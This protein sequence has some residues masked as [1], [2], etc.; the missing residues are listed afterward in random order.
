MEG[1][2]SDVDID[3]EESD[4]ETGLS[5]PISSILNEKVATE[6][7]IGISGDVVLRLTQ[8][9]PAEGNY[10]VFMDN[11]FTSY[12]LVV[13]LKKRGLLSVGTVRPNRVPGCTLKKD[14]E[15]KKAGRGSYDFRTEPKQNIIMVKWLD[16]KPVHLLS[17][18]AGVSP[19]YSA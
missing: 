16:N 9:L 13:E 8:G 2:I 1:D 11:W 7:S 4:D 5:Q 14:D 10:K 12:Q 3:L 6:T 15:L 18:Y 17:S 19:I